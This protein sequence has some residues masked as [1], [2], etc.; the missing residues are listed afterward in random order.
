M[1]TS[2][3]VLAGC[4]AIGIN[5]ELISQVAQKSGAELC[6]EKRMKQAGVLMKELSANTPLHSFDVLSYTLNFD[7]YHCFRSPFPK[8]Y[9]AT[10]VIKFKVDSTLNSVQLNAVN[11]SLVI[12]SVAGKTFTHSGDVLTINLGTTYHAGDTASAFIYYHHNDV[13]DAAFYAANGMVFTD[14][15][16]EGARKWFPCWDRP[17]DKATLDLTAKVPSE[18]KFG[19]N[20]RLVD[21]LHTGDTTYY[22]WA[23]RDPIATYLMV[24]T[25]KVAYNL[26]VVFW[27]KISNPNDSI[28]VHFYW[29]SGEN[30]S[31]LH[32]IET[33][34]P[35]MATRYSTLFGEY[36]FE[37]IGMATIALGAGFI[38]GGMENQTL[39]SLEPNTWYENL[40]SHEF[41]HHWFGD[42]ISPGTWA[43]VWLNEGFATYCEAL[44]NEYKYGQ[45]SYKEAINN[46]AGEYL[47][48]NPGW[49]IYNP[50]WAVTTPDLNTMFNVAITYDK[51]ACVLHMLRYT[52]GDSLFFAC[53]KGYT[54][55][56]V[57]F[58]L[59]NAVTA[60]FIQKINSGAG[61][62]LNW[63]FNEWVMQPNHPI[64]HNVLTIDSAAH[65][66]DV[67]LRQTQSNPSFFTMPVELKISFANSPDSTIR[68]F[69]SVNGQ[70]ISYTFADRPTR[71][72]F[73][74][75]DNIVLK[76]DS[77]LVTGVSPVH[78]IAAL[79]YSLDQ[80]YP[81]PFNP[82]TKI[83]F[84]VAELQNVS[85]KIYD[86]LGKEVATLLNA[87]LNPGEYTI[88]WDGSK[89]PS[90][91]YF[92][93]LQ[94]G[95]YT[96]TR[97]LMLV[98]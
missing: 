62:D 59:K 63:F 32:N 37:K 78:G 42:M 35:S 20:G 66:V 64:Y 55:D 30:V 38:W 15:E 21:T 58:R 65:R 70:T 39:I 48:E 89:A 33:E 85:L 51:G 28:P 94:A 34:V 68:V 29:N 72:V 76:V 95:A 80:N 92:Y 12:D 2:R 19:S 18:A 84:T 14:C 47:F 36:P 5:A 8:S 44:W 13:A 26:D 87:R 9:T 54:T 77:T 61:Q 74:P 91:V 45:A 88:Q 53:L 24:M 43:D 96:Q 79:H 23:S 10:D 56:T 83:E 1:I 97:K 49:P 69:N 17:S 16:P 46:D 50:Q 31:S 4:L 86:I 7:I 25:G 98:K 57:S 22:H 52:L 71:A 75:N 3:L 93:R 67:L 90:G 82:S 27:K 81:N 11:A 73:D 40:V 60:D 6:S 41:A